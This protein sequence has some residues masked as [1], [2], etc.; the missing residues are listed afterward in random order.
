MYYIIFD[1]F[2]NIHRERWGTVAIVQIEHPFQIIAL[3]CGYCNFIT[4]N[5]V[6]IKDNIVKDIFIIKSKRQSEI[7]SF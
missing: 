4:R 3:I 5:F 2:S 1:A 7:Y 6:L